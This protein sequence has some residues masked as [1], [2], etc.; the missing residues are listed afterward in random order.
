M[1]W[2]YLYLAV[3]LFTLFSFLLRAPWAV[4]KNDCECIDNG[5]RAAV[6]QGHSLI[7]PACTLLIVATIFAILW[8]E[9]YRRRMHDAGWL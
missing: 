7:G 3:A 8:P 6:L 2:L 9:M 1:I 5:F 4:G